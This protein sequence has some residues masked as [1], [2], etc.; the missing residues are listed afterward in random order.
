M[1][2]GDRS[3]A[4]EQEKSVKCSL[5]NESER[6]LEDGN[7]IKEEQF[8]GFFRE[9]W[10]YF[11]AH[12]DGTFVVVISAEI[13]VGPHLDAILKASLHFLCFSSISFLID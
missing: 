9:A 3:A 6:V 1:K 8:V 5:F 13:V 7:L 12:R 4:A 10:P 2:A 11:R